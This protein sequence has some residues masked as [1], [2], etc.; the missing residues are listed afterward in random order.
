MNIYL[1]STCVLACHLA[2][3]A[4]IDF[5]RHIIP[6]ALNIS[7]ALCGFTVSVFMFDR[8]PVRIMI[9]SGATLAGLIAISWIYHSVRGRIGIGAGD[10]KLLGAAAA[11]VGAA[12]IPWIILTA[13]ISGLL[14]AAATSISG[15]DMT[16]ET[17]IAFGPHLSMGLMLVWLLRDVIGG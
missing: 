8:S 16:G 4:A 17:R 2:A 12:G 10:M 3:I 6:N 5:R 9:E 14:F 7:L 11:W 1:L 13:S 15:K